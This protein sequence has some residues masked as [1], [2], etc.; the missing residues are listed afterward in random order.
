MVTNEVSKVTSP[1]VEVDLYEQITVLD[2]RGP[3]VV[4]VDE[5]VE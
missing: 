2:I 4:K 3:K 1:Y 5:P